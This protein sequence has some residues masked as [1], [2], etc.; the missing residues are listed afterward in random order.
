MIHYATCPLCQSNHIGHRLSAVDHTV[1]S[2]SF[3]IW[4]CFDCGFLF[5][6]DIPDEQSIGRYYQAAAYV[7]HTDSN[8]GIINS[9]YHRVRNITLKQKRKLIMQLSRLNNGCLLDVGCGTGAFLHEMRSNGWQVKGL[10]PD[11][12]AVGVCQSK[13]GIQPGDLNEL[14][15][16]EPGSFD[17]VTLWH[18]LEHVHT[19]HAYMEQLSNLIGKNG[20]LVIAVPNHT[21]TDATTYK[22]NWAA[23]D[24]P[25]HLY[26]FEP[27]T[28]RRLAQMHGMKVESIKPMWFDSFYVSM[29]SEKNSN[30]KGGILTAFFNGLYSNLKA[31]F[32]KEKC[33]SVIYILSNQ[34]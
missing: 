34:Y 15:S 23:Y 33:S 21:S 10:E 5:T 16:F 9:I 4:Q 31:V 2:Q 24:V 27:T 22:A 17:V 3:E 29:L 8:K 12:T 20:K 13:Y 25:R 11:A 19:L 28:M 6:Q 18:V 14:F 26:H 1:S 30:N 32:N 7:S